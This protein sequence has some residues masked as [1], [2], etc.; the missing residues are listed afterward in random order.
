MRQ[1]ALRS[2]I[3]AKAIIQNEQG[4]VLLL[5][6]SQTD[7]RRPGEWD[8]PGGGIESGEE[9]IAGIIREIHEEAGLSFT[10]EALQLVY[11][12]TEPYAPS[13]ESVTRL[14]FYGQTSM[15]GIQLSFEH[16]HSKWESIEKALIDFPHPFYG[17]GLAYARDNGLL[18]S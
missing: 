4:K 6:R 3:V 11:A 5:R 9:I 7:T 18:K 1:N 10:T 16:D 2:K 12:A 15:T 17:R 14:L 8:F 13:Q